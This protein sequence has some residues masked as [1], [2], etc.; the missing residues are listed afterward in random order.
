VETYRATG[1]DNS[2]QIN[3]TKFDKENALN[4]SSKLL[5]SVKYGREAS[6]LEPLP[7]NRM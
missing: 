4:S 1:A 7:F 3:M 6:W 5:V 2:P